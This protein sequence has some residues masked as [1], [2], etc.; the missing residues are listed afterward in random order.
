MKNSAEYNDI[1]EPQEVYS[2]Y[3]TIAKDLRVKISHLFIGKI[4]SFKGKLE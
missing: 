3:C 1:L 2:K 4:V